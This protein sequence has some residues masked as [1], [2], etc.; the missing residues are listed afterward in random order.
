MVELVLSGQTARFEILMRRHNE[1]LDRAARAIVLD[2][3]EAE[4]VVQAWVNAY[5]HLRQFDGRAS[6]AGSTV[7]AIGLVRVG[8][9]DGVGGPASQNRRLT[10]RALTNV[11][12]SRRLHPRRI[13]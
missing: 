13:L 2:E 8:C 5:A 9:A 11:D 12:S 6:V 10:D 4:D 1:R 7:L 3:R